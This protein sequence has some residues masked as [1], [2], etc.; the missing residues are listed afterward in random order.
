MRPAAWRAK[1]S[2]RVGRN[3][4]ANEH[5]EIGKEVGVVVHRLNLETADRQTIGASYARPDNAEVLTKLVLRGT[6]RLP[7]QPDWTGD[8]TDWMADPLADRNWQ[9]QHHTLRWLNPL[10]W[11]ALEGDE[12]AK[13]EWLRVAKSWLDNNIPA[14]R[15]KR[16]FAWKDMADG[17]RA[18]QLSLGARLVTG[19][20]LDWYVE[21]LRYHRDWLMD[22]AHIVQKNHGMHQHAGLLVVAAVLRDNEGLTVA[23]ERMVRQFETT[24]DHQGGNDE[25]STKYH[26]LNMQWW[27][28]T[29][30]RARLEGLAVPD[31]V[32]AR[33]S[34][35]DMAAAHFTQPDGYMPQIGDSARTRMPLGLGPAV[36]FV[37]SGGELGS[38]PPETVKILDRGYI[39]S[40]S[41]WGQTRPMAQESHMILR[42]GPDLRAH[43]HQDRGSV[44]IYARGRAWLVDSGFYSYQTNDPIR[45]YLASRQAHN[46]AVLNDLPHDDSVSVDL[47]RT[48]VTADFHDFEV[49]DRG[50]PRSGLRR[51]VTYLTEPD[52]WIVWDTA[53]TPER[54]SMTQR[55]HLDLGVAARR[56]DRGFQ[57][58]D[59]DR[60][61]TMAWLG[62][63]P[64][65]RRTTAI[66]GDMQ[67]WIGTRWKTLKPSTLLTA[68][69][70]PRSSHRLVTLIAPSAPREFGVVRSYVDT[71]QTL[72]ATVTRGPRLWTVKMSPATV[73]VKEVARVWE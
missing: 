66:E 12:E 45:R 54:T 55:W 67:G 57:L 28:Q 24:F 65:L 22:E 37:V 19:S 11:C 38:R 40:R 10:R 71:S 31:S 43:E 70:P 3:V 29:W 39:T 17:N 16:N 36:D 2:V 20:D 9:F 51:R 42:Y 41:G 46:L 30:E 73:E 49:E 68:E 62:Q 53:D 61:M 18:I 15:A 64:R 59:R 33:R 63:L 60:S 5:A 6:L 50:Y 7:P 4:R 8:V 32:D 44:H 47:I 56:D 21:G 1:L 69:T 52:C 13:S 23:H 35:A 34:A 72:S 25:G 48:N 14:G 26:V 58:Y 27:D